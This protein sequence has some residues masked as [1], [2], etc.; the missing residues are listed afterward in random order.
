LAGINGIAGALYYY[1]DLLI[2]TIK[3]NSVQ[4]KSLIY[5]SEPDS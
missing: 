1:I 5:A 2:I 3:D 4:Y